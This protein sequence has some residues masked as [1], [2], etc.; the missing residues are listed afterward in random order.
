MPDGPTFDPL[1]LAICD[2]AR[3]KPEILRLIASLP[4]EHDWAIQILADSDP[5]A[6]LPFSRDGLEI[7]TL[8]KPACVN[9]VGREA[10]RVAEGLLDWK[11]GQR[12]RGVPED[13]LPRVLIVMRGDLCLA[14]AWRMASSDKPTIYTD[15]CRDHLSPSWHSGTLPPDRN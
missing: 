13:R 11:D 12:E 14:M 6:I 3:L 10:Y 1:D 9:P 15:A 4:P 7:I 8:A 5:P 2:V